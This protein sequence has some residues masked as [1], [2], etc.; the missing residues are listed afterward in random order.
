M[1]KMTM[2]CYEMVRHRNWLSSIIPDSGAGLS[3]GVLPKMFEMSNNEF[4]S[5][6][7]KRNTAEDFTIP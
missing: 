6:I 4:V 5:E 7:C 2:K 1:Y 3:A